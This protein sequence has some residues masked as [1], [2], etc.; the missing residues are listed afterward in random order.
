MVYQTIEIGVDG[1][2]AVLTLNRPDVRNAFNAA[3]I[4]ELTQ[5]CARLTAQDDVRVVV[6]RG[7]GASFCAGADVGWMRSSLDFTFEENLAD[8]QRMSDMFEAICTLPK[9]VIAR[10]H[11]AAL[12]GGMG[13][14]AACDIVVAASDTVFGFTETKLGIIPAVIS[15]FVVPKIGESWARALFTTGERFGA[16]LA[17]ELGLAHWVCRPEELDSIVRQKTAELLSAGPAAVSAAKRLIGELAIVERARQRDLTA[18]RIASLRTGAEGQEGLRA[19][20][21][22][23]RPTWR[24]ES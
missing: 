3:M 12:G 10:V 18:E 14:M 13:L 4:D 22:K 11:G 21:E 7:S 23:R 1:P 6:L 15:R 8:A 19:F 20:L 5:E 17:H 9:P 16:D 24:L 2:V